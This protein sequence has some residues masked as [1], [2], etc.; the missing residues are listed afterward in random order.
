MTPDQVVQAAHDAGLRLVRFLYTDNGGLIRGK[1]THTAF[2][3][4][5]LTTGMGL[6]RAMQAMNMLDALQTVEDATAVGEIRLVPDPD[7]FVI[8]PY[9]PRTGAMLT[10]MQTYDG[11]IWD[12][13]PRGFLKRMRAQALRQGLVIQAAF[14]NE[15]I[16]VRPDGQGGYAPI[17]E[18]VCFGTIAFAESASMIDALLDAFEKQ[19][20]QVDAFY[21][22]HGHGQQEMPIRHAPDVRA[23]D[24]QVL[25]RET[26]RGVCRQHGWL[27]SFAPKPFPH[28]TGSGCHLHFSAWDPGLQN[29]LF[30]SP[31]DRYNLSGL[32]Y[33][34][35]AGVLEHLP[36]LLGLTT[37][38]YN[39]FRRLQPHYWSSAFTAW[40]PDNR[41]AAVR[42]VAGY[43]GR[44]AS[45]VNMELKASDASSNP[46]LALGGLIAAGLDGIARRL[47]PGEP[48][49]MDPG[50][51]SD[52]E[53]A[54]RG[55]RR[56]PTNQAEALDALERD[57]VLM[58]ALGPS[59]ARSYLAVKRSE[60][61]AFSEQ[62]LAFEIKHHMYKF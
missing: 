2:L 61:K 5:R 44:E 33:H 17:D 16:L 10:D 52:A 6:T 21:P 30:Y 23:A 31:D 51:Y 14:E 13:C 46:Y 3:A 36:G 55:I 12:A 50:L 18:G 29:N 59:L 48:A 15:F 8:L 27:A 42:V 43:R 53:R 28:L 26:V 37:P 7:T 57:A 39:S 49:L 11:V 4:E 60:F 1:A 40:G 54:R 47:D 45:S 56:F 58:A 25:Y 9:A 20:I 34:F 24:N 62:D 32:A 22:E 41:E 38:S 19:G 35:M